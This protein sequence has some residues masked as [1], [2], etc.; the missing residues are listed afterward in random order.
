MVGVWVRTGMP[1]YTCMESQETAST[2]SFLAISQATAV[3]PDAV[4]P[5][6]M[7]RDPPLGMDALP[8]QCFVGHR[9]DL[10]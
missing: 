2:L 6:R 3:L 4:G 7:S 10:E 5:T 8:Q 1:R 9:F